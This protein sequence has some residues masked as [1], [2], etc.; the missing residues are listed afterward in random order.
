M[1]P[2]RCKRVAVY[3]G[4]TGRCSQT[5]L[6]DV[7][8][9][10]LMALVWRSIPLPLRVIA[11]PYAVVV[12]RRFLG[13]CYSLAQLR[14]MHSE[15]YAR[16]LP[17]RLLRPRYRKVT[18]M[19]VHLERDRAARLADRAATNDGL[20]TNGNRAVIRRVASQP[21]PD[22]GAPEYRTRVVARGEYSAISSWPAASNRGRRFSACDRA[23]A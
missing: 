7:G 9:T 13:T 4:A 3:R 14:S 15:K 2:I 6:E 21:Q 5:L 23:N 22:T 1:R 20:G 17:F 19:L 12:Y 11:F 10:G 16:S 8:L 18:R